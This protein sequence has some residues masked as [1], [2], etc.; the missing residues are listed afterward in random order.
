[1]LEISG[2]SRKITTAAF[3][4]LILVQVLIL[5]SFYT[6]LT[7][8]Y[9]SILLACGAVVFTFLALSNFELLS[10]LFIISW[11]LDFDL[12][13]SLRVR[14]ADL[15]AILLMVSF[16]LKALISRGVSVRR[17]PFDMV[18]LI[19]LS[20]MGL[21][22]F[23]ASNLQSGVINYL[24][25]LELF[26]VFAVF[27]YSM[28]I[29]HAKRMLRL[30]IGVVAINSLIS[31]TLYIGQGGGRVFGIGGNEFTDMI[32][33]AFIFTNVFFFFE[34]KPKYRAFLG[35]LLGLFTFALFA[36]GTRGALFSWGIAVLIANLILFL[37]G[38]V[39]KRTILKALFAVPALLAL[40]ILVFGFQTS[41]G[42][43]S[44]SQGY[45]DTIDFRLALWGWAVKAFLSSP[46]L[47]IGLNQF[48]D[49]EQVFPSARINPLF[50]Y[51]KGL[52]AHSVVLNF[53][54]NTGVIGV[55]ALFVF[56]IK[57]LSVAWNLYKKTKYLQD[58]KYTLGLAVVLTYV[59]YSSF[60]A[61]GWFWSL[62]GFE[63]MTFLA[64]LVTFS[65]KF[66]HHNA[67]A[68]VTSQSHN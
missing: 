10:Y 12:T 64:I 25:H 41:H 55:G 28:D 15:L 16:I 39:K 8:I 42:V 7:N 30:F 49:I 27:C 6:G 19:L 31:V 60:Y 59:V 62:N 50:P 44:P 52:D 5:F 33:P 45:V 67:N 35:F 2:N 48:M 34:R 22:L 1:M 47:G 3:A 4:F 61:G 20:I 32:V 9:S 29:S 11:L 53:L 23:R 21:S 14:V 56:F 58:A 26:S 57:I 18:I 24:R 63:F 46:L 13:S 68:V 65:Y 54:A 51:L 37:H 38:K 40:L 17:T 43:T 36:T 66:N